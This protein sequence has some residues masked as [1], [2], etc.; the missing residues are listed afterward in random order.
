MNAILRSSVLVLYRVR[1]LLHNIQ[2]EY[3]KGLIQRGQGSVLLLRGKTNLNEFMRYKDY[4]GYH[5]SLYDFPV[6]QKQHGADEMLVRSK[7]KTK[8][9]ESVYFAPIYA[10]GLG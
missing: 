8:R 2:R 7:A 5:S 3:E 9:R 6:F 1:A 4:I 10:H